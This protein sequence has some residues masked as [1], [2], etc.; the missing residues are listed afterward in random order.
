MDNGIYNILSGQMGVFNNL[1]VVANNVAN[2]NTYGY[3]TDMMLFQQ[4][5]TK[6]V[7]DVNAMPND[8]S[9]ISDYKE[10][11]VKV[12]NR[13]L[14]FSIYGQGFFMV[15]T[16]LGIRYTRNGHFSRNTD[17]V[18][19]TTEGYP[20]LSMD[21]DQIVFQIDDGEPATTGDGSVYVGAEPRGVLGVVHFS[22]PK[23]LRKAENGLF[24]SDIPSEISQQH[25]VVQG[26]LEES[27]VTP[28][29]EM[30]KLI[31]LHRQSELSSSLMD[32]IYSVQKSAYRAFSKQ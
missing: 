8:I 28:I 5:L 25:K 15:Q 11:P 26:T 17:N 3:K 31:E 9:T 21:G 14:D 20:V 6:D 29:L 30:N 16:P 18:L 19:V 12:T 7:H 2:T 32:G 23:L 4:Y 1:N 24:I 22:N 13:S 10:G 27:N